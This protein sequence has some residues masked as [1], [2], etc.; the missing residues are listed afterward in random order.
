MLKF[1]KI[2]VILTLLTTVIVGASGNFLY[3]FPCNRPILYKVG[4]VNQ[5]FGLSREQFISTAK[6]AAGNWNGAAGKNIFQYNEEAPLT[7]NL[8]FDGRQEVKTQVTSLDKKLT[9]DKKTLEQNEAE[10]QE[11]V[12]NFQR[13]LD[14]LNA[15]ISEVNAR[16]GATPEEYEQLKKEQE[17]L[18]GE[19]EQLNE[20]AK[21]LNKSA[22][23]FNTQV[24]KLNQIA[25]DFNSLLEVKPE[26]GL[27]NPEENKIEV[28]F[29]SGRKEL[30]YT[31]MHELGHARGL[32][33]SLSP[34]AIMYP[35]TNASSTLTGD[36]LAALGNICQRKNRAEELKLLLQDFYSSNLVSLGLSSMFWAVTDPS[37]F[38]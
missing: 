22:V 7:V 18:R 20:L 13:G 17:N 9:N 16:G 35:S 29:Y 1:F 21:A 2:P 5:K 15:K 11:G 37:E 19:S 26:E 30:L 31:L 27:Y 12:A 32:S 14:E 34:E 38:S 28:Y 6:E 24:D 4:E 33:H 25:Q 8:V 3:Y 10:Y 23:F 36:D